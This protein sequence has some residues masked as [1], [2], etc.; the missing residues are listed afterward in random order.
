M[1]EKE[2]ETS[3]NTLYIESNNKFLKNNSIFNLTTILFNN[4]GYFF[5]IF[6]IIIIWNFFC[7]IILFS[8]RIRYKVKNFIQK[9]N[10]YIITLWIIRLIIYLIYI[11]FISAFIYLSFIYFCISIIL[12]VEYLLFFIRF[13]SYLK[14]RV[15]YHF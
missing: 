11:Y 10:E 12:F 1:I 5:D 4:K 14:G 13:R 7:Y 8:I 2:V 3:L 6:I 15:I 9:K